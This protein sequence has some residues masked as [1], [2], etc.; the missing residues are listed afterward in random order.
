MSALKITEVFNQMPSTTPN[1]SVQIPTCDG[2]CIFLTPRE[3]ISTSHLRDGGVF[4]LADLPIDLLP[5]FKALCGSV[6]YA[7]NVTV[8]IPGE[9]NKNISFPFT[10]NGSG[11]SENPYH[12]R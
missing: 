10:V 4:A 12:M 1:E 9:P 3:V 11:S 6:K 7:I 8:Q 5:S 2:R